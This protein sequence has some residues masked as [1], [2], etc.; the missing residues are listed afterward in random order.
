MIRVLVV[1]DSLVARE[2]LVHTL[3]SDPDIE[4]AGTASD[5]LEGIQAAAALK[6]DVITMD[7]N[8][9][10]VDGMEATRRIMETAPTR[11]I[12]VTGNEITAEVRATF[13]SLELGALAIVKRP[14]AAS[15]GAASRAELI[16]MV[17]IMSEV[18]VVRRWARRPPRPIEPASGAEAVAASDALKRMGAVHAIAIGAS[19]GGPNAL[20]AILEGLRKDI[21]VPILVVQHIAQGFVE[22]F[23]HWVGE[24]SGFETRVAQ[25][26]EPL[27]PGVVYIAPD[28]THLGV[29]S[30]RK[31]ALA[32]GGGR[33]GLCPSATH[34]FR[35]VAE[36]FGS[37]AAGVILT[38]MGRDGSDG[39]LEMKRRG[40]LTL[41]QDKESSVIWGMPKEA[42]EAGAIDLV[43][44]LEKISLVLNGASH[45]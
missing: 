7:I 24:A 11:I 37:R 22:G 5:G 40:A 28:K 42:I 17:K 18:K 35:S 27:R 13:T 23:A 34:L 45:D 14:E 21:G 43:L 30:E 29:S 41:A 44:P 4:V 33:P 10:R 20:K 36:V 38:G 39:L 12:I 9:P 26:G 8:M 3:N 15:A 2:F 25:D 6:P 32:S 1:E 31:I 16:Q 19:T